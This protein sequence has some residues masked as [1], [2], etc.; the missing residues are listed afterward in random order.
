[1]ETQA[2]QHKIFIR[3]RIRT[4][5]SDPDPAKRLGSFRIRIHNTVYNR[6]ELLYTGMLEDK[7][8]Y[9]STRYRYLPTFSVTDSDAKYQ[10]IPFL[11]QACN[12][13]DPDP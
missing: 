6:T 3:I 1:M 4:N 13:L 7:K 9:Q 10:Y 2:L 8:A 12:D 11:I 5:C